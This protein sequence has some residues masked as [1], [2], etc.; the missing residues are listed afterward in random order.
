[1]MA[2][3]QYSSTDISIQ[4]ATL[5]F[6]SRQFELEYRNYSYAALKRQAR[7]ALVLGLSLWIFYSALD[8]LFVP[9][10][11]MEAIWEIR[12]II[13]VAI[14]LVFVSTFHSIFRHFNQQLLTLLAV[15]G[16][17]GVLTKMLL[18]PGF[19]VS[20]YFPGLILVIFWSHCFSGM[21]FVYA[22][23]ASIVILCA[24]NLIFMVFQPMQ[25]V[26]LASNNFYIVASIALAVCASYV[27]ERQSRIL[28]LHVQNL[29]T[30]RNLQLSRAL[31]DSLTGLP[32]RELLDDRLEQAI[33]QASR[34]EF[35]CAGLFIDLDGFKEI[36]DTHGHSVGDQFLKEVAARFKDIMREAD[37]LSR[38]GGDE[39]F[40]LARN[41]T[42]VE[43]AS[44]LA[45]KLLSQLERSFIL[46][47]KIT[48]SG[49]TASIGI[50]IFPYKYCTPVDVVRRADKAMYEIKR[51]DKAGVA[52]AKAYETDDSAT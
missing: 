9:S 4:P 26:E 49:I 12:S 22:S 38:I 41:I 3:D 1:M 32:N 24:F 42:T 36:N 44:V 33:R 18:L 35:A 27:W 21:R 20:H 47:N 48:I 5:E 37:T 45:D 39:F 23:F 30:E 10:S 28:F 50:C 40:V 6:G 16:A 46:D 7:V 17:T 25:I 34:D 8:S 2:I 29:D 11:Q 15:M 52:F 51:G 31:H 19:A 13:S 43:A 14:I